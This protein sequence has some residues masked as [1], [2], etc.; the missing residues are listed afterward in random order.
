MGC[1]RSLVNLS[2]PG[3]GGKRAACS[4]RAAATT[5]GSGTARRLAAVLGG[6]SFGTAPFRLCIACFFRAGQTSGATLLLLP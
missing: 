5:S 2:P 4:A 6:P 3:P 1:P